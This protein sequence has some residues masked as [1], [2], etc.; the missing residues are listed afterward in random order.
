MKKIV[1]LSGIL[2][3]LLFCGAKEYTVELPAAPGTEQIFFLDLQDLKADS[4]TF[5]VTT[6]EGKKVPFSFDMQLQRSGT[7]GQ[8][9]SS[10]NGFYSKEWAP[11]SEKKFEVPGYL[12]FRGVPGVKKY[13]FKFKDG[14]KETLS[15]PDP[16]VRGW[17]IELL[18][19]PYLKNPASVTGRKGYYKMLPGGGV[20]FTY[21]IRIPR[22][23]SAAD[24]RI[25]GRR[26][27][28][29]V[30]AKGAFGY[31]NIPLKNGVWDI[32]SVISCYIPHSPDRFQDTCAEGLLAIKDLFA[33]SRNNIW[34][35]EYVKGPSVLKEL[36]MQLPPLGREMGVTLDS[37]LFN[38]GDVIEIKPYGGKGESGIP[39]E[40]GSV[41]GVRYGI[42]TGATE[43]NYTLCDASGKVS[44]KGKG[45]KIHL[46][47]IKEGTYTLTIRLYLDGVFAMK[48]EFSIKIQ[49]SPF[50]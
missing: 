27:F 23:A 34:Q 38:T 36:H 20:E 13:F 18:R 33:R 15:R 21:P 24:E 31:F 16:A 19:D 35:S 4:S 14:A 29:L 49:P 2:L 28:T 26:I 5:S 11:A 46:D 17:W 30:R 41:K 44:L 47:R 1:M 7:E 8:Y 6:P 32:T 39:F 9:K 22:R 45:K 42:W 10:V 48:K 12:S 25:A 37:D 43:V 50:Q 40:S 3:P